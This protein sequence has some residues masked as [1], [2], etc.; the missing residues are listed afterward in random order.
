MK[1]EI[2]KWWTK[3][4]KFKVLKQKNKKKDLNSLI[5][6]TF[7]CHCNPQKELQQ[8]PK[9][10]IVLKKISFVLKLTLE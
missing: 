4:R 3:V 7:T 10:T 8:S 6:S 9:T 1:Q 5:C 2:E